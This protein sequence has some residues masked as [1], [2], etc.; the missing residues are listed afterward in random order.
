M[1]APAQSRRQFVENVKAEAELWR[2]T[3]QRGKITLM[4]D[5]AGPPGTGYIPPVRAATITTWP[6][7]RAEVRSIAPRGWRTK[8]RF[9]PRR[10]APDT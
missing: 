8:P 1:L 2:E 5:L 4:I 10:G 6:P 9:K 7:E 3:V